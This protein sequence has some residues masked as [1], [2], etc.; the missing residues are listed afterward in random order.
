MCR[1]SLESQSYSVETYY[2]IVGN[3]DALTFLNRSIGLLNQ[4]I[5]IDQTY[6]ICT[7]S[8][9]KKLHNL[10]K[11]FDLNYP[12][13]ILVSFGPLTSLGFSIEFFYFQIS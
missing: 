5:N 3:S 11:F 2:N 13:F 7:F 1:F 12:Y 8:R 10:D 9:I 4:T 6:L